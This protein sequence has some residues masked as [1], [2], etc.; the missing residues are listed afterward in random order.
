MDLLDQVRAAGVVG[1][2]G[3]G[4]PTHLKLRNRAEVLILNACE[5]EPLLKADQQL[6]V[7][8]GDKVLEGLALAAG[9]LRAERVA[10]GLKA[11]YK[12][13][14]EAIEPPAAERRMEIIPLGDHYPVGDEHILV[15]EITGRTVPP[16]GIPLQVG[17][18]VLN[19]ETAFNIANA[20]SSRPVTEK[21]LS[22]AGAVRSPCTLRVPVGTPLKACIEA[23]GGPTCEDHVLAVG[24][25]MTGTF[26]KDAGLPVDKRTK[27]VVVVPAGNRIAQNAFLSL[28]AMSRRTGTACCLCR[29]C[30]DLCPRYLLGHPIEPH[31][32]MRAIAHFALADLNLLK[33]SLLCSECRVCDRYACPMDLCPGGVMGEIKRVLLGQRVTAEWRL[34]DDAIAFDGRRIPTSRLVARLGLNAYDRD[35]PLL[36]RAVETRTVVLPLAQ[37]YG[38]P[39][40]PT[41]KVGDRVK[42]GDMVAE[43]AQRAPG[44]HV[45][46]SIPGVV[47][48]VNSSITIEAL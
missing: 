5:C 21:F 34:R 23:A 27:A 12:S 26:T 39:A 48:K 6:L 7:H 17:T 15:K 4:F 35:A 11:K 32:V 13:V 19:V 45:H 22:V 9:Q 41:V 1:A 37:H 2:G 42:V 47:T 38:A 43:A 16:G 31:K 46:A 24:G 30:T 14:L 44:A 29:A 33:M 18:V 40:L 25:P 20:A 36:P 8:H 10:I 28:H 3:A